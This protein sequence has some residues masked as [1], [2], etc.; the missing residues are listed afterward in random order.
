MRVRARFEKHRCSR[1]LELRMAAQH[2]SVS[3]FQSQYPRNVTRAHPEW[4][5]HFTLRIIDGAIPSFGTGKAFEAQANVFARTCPGSRATSGFVFV[6][7]PGMTA[8]PRQMHFSTTPHDTPIYCRCRLLRL[9][10]MAA[11][12]LA[13]VPDWNDENTSCD[14]TAMFPG[15]GGGGS[16]AAATATE[17][18]LSAVAPLDGTMAPAVLCDAE[19]SSGPNDDAMLLTRRTSEPK[20]AAMASVCDCDTT[21]DTDDR[22]DSA[23]SSKFNATNGDGSTPAGTEANNEW[24]EVSEESDAPDAGA[25]VCGGIVNE[26]VSL[27]TGA[28]ALCADGAF[29]LGGETTCERFAA[30]KTASGLRPPKAACGGAGGGAA[31]A[32]AADCGGGVG[33]PGGAR[34]G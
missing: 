26:P 10:I 27:I 4:Q 28:A 9:A 22:R 30:A 33:R 34:G 8:L 17:A 24:R 20:A 13:P 31:E 12:E 6:T 23:F 2:H 32:A 19:D 14:S 11:Q 25:R 16:S 7:K 21:E 1:K 18:P 5:A 3:I 29:P 15:V